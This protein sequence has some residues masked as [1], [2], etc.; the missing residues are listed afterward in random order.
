MGIN[1]GCFPAICQVCSPLSLHLFRF[2]I[3]PSVLYFQ[4]SALQKIALQPCRFFS[5]WF[6][7]LGSF[8]PEH[9]LLLEI[10]VFSVSLLSQLFFAIDF[11]CEIFYIT[12]FCSLEVF[13]LLVFDFSR[14]N[15]EAF[16]VKLCFV[17]TPRRILVFYYKF[18]LSE[19][20]VLL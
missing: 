19:I 18:F 9:F 7:L 3:M 10:F 1:G 15:C 20:Y 4:F 16:I 17:M 6:L 12:C 8:Y 5:E 11:S 14:T 13:I 2:N